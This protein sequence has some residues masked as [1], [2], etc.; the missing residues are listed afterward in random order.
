V[1][2][3]QQFSGDEPVEAKTA[4]KWKINN[5]KGDDVMGNQCDSPIDKK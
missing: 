5:T 2:V 3:E 4:A 1:V